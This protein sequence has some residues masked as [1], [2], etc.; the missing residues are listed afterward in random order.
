MTIEGV[1]GNLVKDPVGYFTETRYRS[2]EERRQFYARVGEHEKRFF[3][4]LCGTH[5]SS[6]NNKQWEFVKRMM[7]RDMEM[8]V[9]RES[10]FDGIAYRNNYFRNLADF[11]PREISYLKHNFVNGELHGGYQ[12]LEPRIAIKLMLMADKL[13]RELGDQEISR[14][15]MNRVIGLLVSEV[16]SHSS[17]RLNNN[18]VRIFDEDQTI[19]ML[20]EN[21]QSVGIDP[22]YFDIKKMKLYQRDELNRIWQRDYGHLNITSDG[23]QDSYSIGF[24][25]NMHDNI[26]N[27]FSEEERAAL[28]SLYIQLIALPNEKI[29]SLGHQYFIDQIQDPVLIIKIAVLAK[30]MEKSNPNLTLTERWKEAIR[31]VSASTLPR[32]ARGPQ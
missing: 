18:F 14:I 5:P 12:E 32:P 7:K 8:T 15:D 3:E 25:G 16:L 23:G 11:S 1:V 31:I 30:K 24:G 26:R 13:L 28:N 4:G 17:A 2:P 21:L 27:D 6:V 19:K 9:N 20:V 22:R 10:G 29:S